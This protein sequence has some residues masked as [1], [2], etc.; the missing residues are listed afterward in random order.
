MKELDKAY[1][2]IDMLRAL[3]LPVSEEQLG[4]ISKLEKE[5]LLNEIIPL[6]K[7]ELE[8]MAS[9]MRSNFHLEVD[10]IKSKGLSIQLSETLKQNTNVASETEERGDRKKKYII[11]VTFPDNRI[12]CHRIVT[13]TFLD[14]IKY[15]GP[16]NVEKLGITFLGINLVSAVLHENERYHAYQHEVENGLYVCTY[17]NTDRKLEVLKTINRDLNL[18]LIIEKIKFE[19]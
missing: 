16:T 5:Y 17:L 13:N 8:P 7:Q 15:A 14:V 19:D 9:R 12:S 18:N 4:A 6:L 2:A 11:R 1:E 10:Y 3:N